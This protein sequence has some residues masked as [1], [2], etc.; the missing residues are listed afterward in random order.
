MEQRFAKRQIEVREIDEDK[1]TIGGLAVPYGEV[2][3]DMGFTEIIE[4]GAFDGSLKNDVIKCLWSH[5]SSR[6]LGS[7]K[8]KTL[9]LENKSDGIHFENDL[10]DTQTGK[11]AQVLIERG[12][13]DGVSFGF[14]A[15]EDEWNDKDKNNIIRTIK[16]GEL[17]EISPVAFPAY[18]QTG[19]SLRSLYEA[20]KK[21][22]EPEKQTLENEER[23]LKLLEVEQ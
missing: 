17:I 6:V 22:E 19:V 12:D 18:P 8:N 14:Y 15:I 5:E 9:R 4:P 7:T 23:E 3:S 1:K 13:V 2:S 10:P 11:E 16:K 20:S 21:N